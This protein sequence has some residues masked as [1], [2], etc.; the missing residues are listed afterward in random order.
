MAK[1]TSSQL[2]TAFGAALMLLAAS[3][4]RASILDFDKSY[5]CDYHFSAEAFGNPVSSVM[6]HAGIEI[7]HDPISHRR[8]AKEWRDIKDIQLEQAAAGFVGQASFSTT[9]Y[10]GSLSAEVQP[11]LQFWVTFT[12]G[13]SVILNPVIAATTADFHIDYESDRNKAN[14]RITAWQETDPDSID[15]VA[16]LAT[17][18]IT[19]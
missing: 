11:I 15:R 8:G 19:P 12:D 13:T 17:T 5:Y 3:P 6:V 7:T 16:C 18:Q 10:T 4:A 9:Y 14:L 1:H 2:R